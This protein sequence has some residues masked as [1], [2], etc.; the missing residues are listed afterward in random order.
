M[1]LSGPVSGS[2]NT[3]RMLKFFI[4]LQFLVTILSVHCN[5][6]EE[7]YVIVI[8]PEVLFILIDVIRYGAPVGC[9]VQ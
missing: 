6:Q 2:V 3:G 7:K 8:S 5:K 4:S 9:V 1:T